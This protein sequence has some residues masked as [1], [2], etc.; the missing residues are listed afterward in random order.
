MQETLKEQLE[1][2]TARLG[3]VLNAYRKAKQEAH[4]A[5][6]AA[7]SLWMKAQDAMDE[8]NQICKEVENV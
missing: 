2:A 3:H 5:S 8:W 6:C 1:V 4:L 7:E